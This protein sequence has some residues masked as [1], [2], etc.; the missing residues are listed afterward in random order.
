MYAVIDKFRQSII[1][2]I[3]P[4]Y[5]TEYEWLLQNIGQ[6]TSPAYQQRYKNQWAMNRARLSNSFYATYFGLLQQKTAQPLSTL[7]QTLYQSSARSNG[8]QSLQFSFATKLLHTLNPRL[9]IYDSRVARFFL[10]DEPQTTAPLQQRISTLI[11]FH[12]FLVQEYARV[13]SLDLLAQAIADFRQRFTPRQ[14]TDEK[15]IDW[16]IWGL[17]VCADKGML[18]NGQI[19]YG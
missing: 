2:A 10:F 16:L 11:D 1:G 13:L 12:N 18:L 15:I 17:V 6:A 7:C 5:V 14:H 9:P 3:D 4:S 8:T 19:A